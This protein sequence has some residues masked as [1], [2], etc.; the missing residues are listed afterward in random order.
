MTSTETRT[1]ALNGAADPYA[2]RPW[3]DP[4]KARREARLADDITAAAWRRT[5]NAKGEEI[6]Q[7]QALAEIAAGEDAE[8]WDDITAGWDDPPP[9]PELVARTDGHC[10]AYVGQSGVIGGASEGGK[11]RLAD[12]ATIQELEAGRPVI[13]WDME[14]GIHLSRQ[15]LRDMGMTLEQAKELLRYRSATGLWSHR[16]ASAMAARFADEGG[17]LVVMDSSTAIA[18]A[19]GLEVS[20]GKSEDVQALYAQALHPWKD[21]GLCPL[22]IDNTN[23]SGPLDLSG[24]Q[25]KKSGLD[26]GLGVVLRSPHGVGHHGSADVFVLKDRGASIRYVNRQLTDGVGEV[27][28]YFGK[29]TST[30][31]PHRSGV[32]GRGVDFRISPP[33]EQPDHGLT[34]A[35]IR[36]TEERAALTFNAAALLSLLPSDP[37]DAKSKNE[38][39]SEMR[40]T[41]RIKIGNSSSEWDDLLTKLGPQVGRTAG[42]QRG[43]VRFYRGDRGQ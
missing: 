7:A 41:K 21:A 32:H 29:L 6:R 10:G 16:K 31:N 23:K 22:A 2:A 18:H 36:E 15:A 20:G 11:T 40:V 33:E 17:R 26:F 30:P 4:D 8:G 39:L 37:D 34:P 24:S 12:M 43:T 19:L 13:R 5:V 28:R 42:R 25:H 3:T 1:G 27:Y 35:E 14:N 38:L 9:T